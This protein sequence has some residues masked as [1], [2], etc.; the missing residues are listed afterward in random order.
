MHSWCVQGVYLGNISLLLKRMYVN[1]E[2]L[3]LDNISL[4]LKRMY[5]NIEIIPKTNLLW[6]RNLLVL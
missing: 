6:R 2:T 3:H 1:I 4:L 5:V